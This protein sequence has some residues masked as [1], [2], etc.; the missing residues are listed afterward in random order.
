MKV[1][2]T[3][4]AIVIIRA[5]LLLRHRF[6]ERIQS[7]NVT[8]AMQGVSYKELDGNTTKKMTNYLLSIFALLIVGCGNRQTKQIVHTE[9]DSTELTIK[10][11]YDTVHF[12]F[13]WRDADSVSYLFGKPSKDKIAEYQRR[14]DSL[15]RTEHYGF[16]DR[17]EY[18]RDISHITA[19]NDFATLWFATNTPYEDDLDMILWRINECYP[20]NCST[21]EIERYQRFSEQIDS[22]LSGSGW[23]SKIHSLLA[24]RLQRCKV[25][26]YNYRLLDCNCKS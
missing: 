23:N 13:K 22:L 4:V 6:V 12:K 8:V 24:A 18:F 21:T 11:P 17:I 25:E 2:I 3:I 26:F 7:N 15:H 1:I 5:A 20:L 10:T 16:Y 14:F 19:V 9:S